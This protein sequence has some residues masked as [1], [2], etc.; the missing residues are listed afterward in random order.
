MATN[1]ELK[2]RCAD[3]NTTARRG[4]NL[5]TTSRTY[6]DQIDTYFNVSQ[7]RLKL[8][9]INGERAEL[10]Q[11]DRANDPSIRKSQYTILNL[12]PEQGRQLI[13]QLTVAIGTRVIVKK[14]RTLLMWNDVRI[15]LDHVDGLGDFIEFEG[16]VGPTCTEAQAAEKVAT[17]R[18]HFEIRD[19]DLIS[20]S[21]SDL[22]LSR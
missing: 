11:Y 17:L 20:T 15:H 2:A 12:T 3:M 9:E 21:Y 13:A 14:R 1:I 22:L 10:I 4:E 6:L 5:V 18:K 19:E 8:R 7:G 16:L